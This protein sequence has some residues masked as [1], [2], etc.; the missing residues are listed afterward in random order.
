MKSFNRALFATSDFEI[1]WQT[2]RMSCF[3]GD[4]GIDVHS[5]GTHSLPE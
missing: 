3:A 5:L 4:V 1:S 2:L